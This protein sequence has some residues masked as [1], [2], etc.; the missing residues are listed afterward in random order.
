MCCTRHAGMDAET[1]AH[2]PRHRVW[3]HFQPQNF[4]CTEKAGC[5]ARE[6]SGS[7]DDGLRLARLCIT[8]PKQQSSVFAFNQTDIIIATMNN[9]TTEHHVKADCS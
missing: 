3:Q 2:I 5:S 8:F 4:Y 6:L 7:H 1:F 9:S